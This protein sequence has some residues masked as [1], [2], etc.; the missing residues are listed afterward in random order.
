[1]EVGGDIEVADGLDVEVASF[2]EVEIEVGDFAALFVFLVFFVGVLFG[3]LGFIGIDG[4]D[5]GPTGFVFVEF[6]NDDGLAVAEGDIFAGGEGG[7]GLGEG[8]VDHGIEPLGVAGVFHAF[9]GDDVGGD[10]S[11]GEVAEA[12]E[13]VG[14]GGDAAEDVDFSTAEGQEGFLRSGQ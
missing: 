6:G 12:F 11:V 10:A 4:S 13:A 1:V 8:L 7:H 2:G 14:G 3:I 5:D 9:E